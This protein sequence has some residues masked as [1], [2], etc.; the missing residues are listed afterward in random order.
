VKTRVAVKHSKDC[1]GVKQGWPHPW[2]IIDTEMPV[3]FLTA[4]GN[5]SKRIFTGWSWLR[6]RCADSSCPAILLVRERDV[7]DLAAKGARP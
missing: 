6:F 5:V 3:A 2:S 4:S 1:V 7:L